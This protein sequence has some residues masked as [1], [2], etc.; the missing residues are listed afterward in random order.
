MPNSCPPSSSPRRGSLTAVVSDRAQIVRVR[1]DDFLESIGGGIVG[2]ACDQ[3]C[4]QV[5]VGRVPMVVRRQLRVTAVRVDLPGGFAQQHMSTEFLASATLAQLGERC[6]HGIERQRLTG[7]VRVRT[8]I[9]G[10]AMRDLV[11]LAIERD[12]QV[13]EPGRLVVDRSRRRR[14]RPPTSMTGYESRARA[15]SPS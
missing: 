9:A 3:Q 5:E 1:S 6:R 13:H 7:Q 15:C 10:E 14:T 8:E 2:G 4:E 11:E 12:E